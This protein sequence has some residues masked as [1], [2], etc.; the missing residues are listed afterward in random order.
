MEKERCK[1]RGENLGFRRGDARLG[2]NDARKEEE[3]QAKR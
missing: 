1:A 2:K 3:K